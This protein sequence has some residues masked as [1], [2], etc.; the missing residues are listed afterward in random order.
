MA[1]IASPDFVR[2]TW[3]RRE[4]FDGRR[5]P[6]LDADSAVHEPAVRLW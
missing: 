4:L 1:V 5:I 3:A 2:V 6:I